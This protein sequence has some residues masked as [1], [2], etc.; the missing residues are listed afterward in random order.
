MRIR[1]WLFAWDQQQG[2]GQALGTR[3][4]DNLLVAAATPWLQ[5]PAPGRGGRSQLLC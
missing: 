5:A 3:A 4:G 1:G 2:R